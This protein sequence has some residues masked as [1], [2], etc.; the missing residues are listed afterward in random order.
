MQQLLE[1]DRKLLDAELEAKRYECSICYDEYVIA[2]I[3]I[4][5]GCNHKYEG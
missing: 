5:D 4:L 2:D 3:F 1:E